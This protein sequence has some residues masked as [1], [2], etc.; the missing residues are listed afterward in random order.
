M[1]QVSIHYIYYLTA[2]VVVGSERDVWHGV[3]TAL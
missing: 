2:V 1:T 3:I